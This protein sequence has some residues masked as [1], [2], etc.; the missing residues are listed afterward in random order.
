MAPE[1][2]GVE[3]EERHVL[4]RSRLVAGGGP[5]EGVDL[6]REGKREGVNDESVSCARQL[7]AYDTMREGD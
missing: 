4:A 2:F 6:C 3:V 5:G 7:R 1:V